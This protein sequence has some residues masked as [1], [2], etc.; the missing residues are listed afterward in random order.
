VNY[1]SGGYDTRSVVLA[2]V[3]SDGKPD[4]IVANYCA[5]SGC[6]NGSVS[7][8]LGNGD[9]TF[10]PAVSYPSGGYYSFS[11]A[12]GDVNGDGKPDL[13]VTNECASSTCETNGGS[14]SVLLG[15][16]DG[17]FQPAV[18]YALGEAYAVSVAVGDV[19]GD[20]K[21]DLVVANNCASYNNCANGSVSVLLG[22]G[23]GTFQPA[24]SYASGGVDSFSVAVVDVN[25]DGKPDVVMANECGSSG[26]CASGSVSVLL[27]NGDGTFQP[28]VSY[29]SGGPYSLSVAVGDVNGDGKPDLVVANV[30]ASGSVSVL[31]GNGDGTFQPAVSYA[32]GGSN[33][34]SVAMGDVN[35]DGKP[36][37]VVAN[38]CAIS[39]CQTS[40]GSVGVLLGNG[41]GTFRATVGYSSDVPYAFSVA[42]GDVNG[43]GKPDLVV[44]NGCANNG[45]CQGGNQIGGS[46]SVLLGN[47]DGTFQPAVSY[48]SGGQDALSVAVGDVNGDGKLDL[49]VAN[50]CASSGSCANGSVS[51]LLGNGDGTFQSAVNYASGGSLAYS[52][53]VGDVNGDGK[54]DIVVANECAS[55]NCANGAVSVL[56][57]NGDGTFQSAVS[58]AS[59]GSYTYSVAVGDVNG[60]GKPDVIVTNECANSSCQ[61]NGGSVSVLL[62]NG[63][64]TFQSAV[65]YASGVESLSVA[66][67]DVNSDGKLDLI[68]ANYCASSSSCSDGSVSVLLGNGDGTFQPA[69]SYPSSEQ[70]AS[71]LVVGD[72]NGDGK[73]D[74]VATQPGSVALFLGNGDGTFQPAIA[75]TPGGQGLAVGDFNHDGKPDL[76]TAGGGDVFVLLNIASSFQYATSTTISSSAN[77]TSPGQSVTF[78]ATVT[79]A[80]S[81]GALTGSITLYDGATA[82]DTET[83]NN[84]TATFTTSSLA[85]GAHSLTASYSGDTNYLASTSQAFTENV[86]ST[87]TTTTLAAS[88]KP[89]TY[90]QSVTLTATVTP[91]GSGT[92]TGTVTFLDG[93]NNVG[94]AMLSGS[95]GILATSSLNA[96][97]HSITASYGGD[98]NFSAS[99]SSALALSVNQAASTVSL[100]SSANPSAYNQA[101]T[102]VASVSPQYAGGEATGTVT[103]KDGAASI[104]STGVS[105]NLASLTLNSLAV[106]T[107]SITAVYSGDANLTGNS[108]SAVRE[109]V[110]KATTSSS[111][112]SSA[113]PST[114]GEAV[115]FTITVGPQFSGTPTGTVTLKKNGSSLVTLLL[116]SG[117]ASY[118]TSS[119]AVGSD[120]MTAAY[121]GDSNFASSTSPVLK[122]VVNKVA[123][124]TTV[125]SSSNLSTVGQPVTFTATISSSG[126]A[127]PNGEVVT[128]KNGGVTLGTFGLSGG[129]ATFTSTLLTAGTHAI[130]ATYSGDATFSAS[131][132]A[133]LT[134]T[135]DKYGTTSTV[136]SS[137]SPSSFGQSVAFTATVSSSGPTPTGTVT[138]KSGTNTLGTQMLSGGAATL[139][140][141]TLIVGTHSITVVYS[142]DANNAASTSTAISQVVTKAATSITLTASPNPSMTGQ[143]VTFTA[144]VTSSTTGTPTGS[145][146]FKFGTKTLGTAALSAGVA[147]LTTT[148]LA[149]GTDTI[150]AT[151]NGSA[152]FTASSTTLMQSVQ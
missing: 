6:S 138:F 132:S 86:N 41:D 19:N 64:G 15:N 76:A 88:P 80:F 5:I 131:T 97:S 50:Y 46:A 74:I 141:S 112:T 84:G 9:G 65:T 61:T 95:M 28:A 96:G 99:T 116:N 62:G 16:G 124:T 51:V 148:S 133:A 25:G 125:T 152:D 106:G 17:T 40:G 8:L 63:D 108:S 59:G 119:F 147:M 27:G 72:F 14:V 20:G 2:D 7:V 100:S 11:A 68:V 83:V 123:T 56:L 136:T 146:T 104:G 35:S 128:F 30:S 12:A 98:S 110:N 31:L 122:Q 105:G 117:Q 33:S 121:S 39:N 143:S 70:G 130:T 38:E 67:A 77:P 48:A 4:L 113:N 73:P 69:V 75:Y 81:V 24:V 90:G 1:A 107:H 49:I 111:V 42:V 87:V 127:P 93:A 55:S 34:Y 66:V 36:D 60:D 91:T 103:F 23:D 79:T 142:G 47:G 101:V 26:N 53:A 140:D 52:V 21:P 137:G 92:P 29:P 109:V 89:S 135:V 145:V 18:T 13:I 150:T 78:T 37:I 32:S 120:N 85:L 22:N 102:F 71:G 144:T 134:Q 3:N 44:A 82:L 129:T 126:G 151:Y 58:Y 43:D 10:Q 118:T 139:N 57:G 114:I 54:P 115:T 94:S 45:G 149:T